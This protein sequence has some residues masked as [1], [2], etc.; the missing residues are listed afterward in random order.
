[1]NEDKERHK[2]KR[3]RNLMAKKLRENPAFRLRR[4]SVKKREKPSKIKLADY[5]KGNL[6][7]DD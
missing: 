7:D 1:M 3:Q 6:E 4:T 2:K 5:L